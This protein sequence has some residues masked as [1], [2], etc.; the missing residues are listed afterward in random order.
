[1]EP[2][3]PDLELSEVSRASGGQRGSGAAACHR[4][5]ASPRAPVRPALHVLLVHLPGSSLAPV[6]GRCRSRGLR[7][8]H[9]LGLQ[10][11]PAA[12][13]QDLGAART[14]PATAQL[15]LPGVLPWAAKSPQCHSQ[16]SANLDEG[17]GQ[18]AGCG[19]VGICPS[20]LGPGPAG[21]LP[22]PVSPSAN[23]TCLAGL[24]W[25]E[26]AGMCPRTSICPSLFPQT[27][28][29]A[30]RPSPCASAQGWS[31]QAPA[32]LPRAQPRHPLLRGP[33]GRHQHW[34]QSG[35]P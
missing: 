21:G 17:H 29:E 31:T 9:P 15:A 16:G 4:P 23:G 32:W 3:L 30:P 1:M 14:A 7:P 35:S 5:A 18:R 22:E 25:E 19:A 2:L 11:A 10:K 28:T 20:A 24:G 6:W 13:R 12:R 26:R 34:A 33:W 8:L 27:V